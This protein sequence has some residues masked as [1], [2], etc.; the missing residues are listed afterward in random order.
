[1]TNVNDIGLNSEALFTISRTMREQNPEPNEIMPYSEYAGAVSTYAV[2]KAM[3]SIAE[4][5][6]AQEM[7]EIKKMIA[8]NE[9]RIN[10]M[11]LAHDTQYRRGALFTD[12]EFDEWL[13]N[14]G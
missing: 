14:H 3:E 13:E 12:T 10:A 6:K 1:M 5:L 8:N 2:I 11:R 9:R 7:I 4:G